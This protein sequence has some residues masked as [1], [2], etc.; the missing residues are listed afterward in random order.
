M[1]EVYTGLGELKLDPEVIAVG[2][3]ILF[4]GSRVPAG[5]QLCDGTN[6]TPD[7]RDR[8]IVGASAVGTGTAG[9]TS[10]PTSI[11]HTGFALGAHSAHSPTQPSAHSAH[12]PTQP[13]T[14]S[15]HVSTQPATHPTHATN[16]THT[17]DSHTLVTDGSVAVSGSKL[18]GPQPHSSDG[19][20]THD[21][22][23]AHASWGVNAHS[24]HAGFAVDA[25]SAHAAF[26]VDAHSAHSVTQPSAHAFKHDVLAFLMKV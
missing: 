3:I 6:G 20:H 18:T 21:A 25:H 19:G 10:S 24:A 23:P 7:L 12:S 9:G 8:I 1:S 2:T 22:H 16:A 5:W 11:T 15:G 13:A 14:H 4:F 17:H 26:A